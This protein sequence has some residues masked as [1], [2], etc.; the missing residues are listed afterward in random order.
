MHDC[1]PE[2]LLGCGASIR[3]GNRWHRSVPP[4]L[5]NACGP[6]AWWGM[7]LKKR[8]KFDGACTAFPF[9]SACWMA[10]GPRNQIHCCRSAAARWTDRAPGPDDLPPDGRI[11]GV[12]VVDNVAVVRRRQK[13][14]LCRR[15]KAERRQCRAKV[16]PRGVHRTGAGSKSRIGALRVN[17]RML[18]ETFGDRAKQLISVCP[19]CW[20]QSVPCT[21]PVQEMASFG[22]WSLS[23]E[24]IGTRT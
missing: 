20:P 24:N 11:L 23:T 5:I 22:F 16:K 13:H 10:A 1:V 8:K 17:Q 6:C 3:H 7:V 2:G 12:I 9:C 19:S 21:T 14:I 15:D 18:L 4:Q